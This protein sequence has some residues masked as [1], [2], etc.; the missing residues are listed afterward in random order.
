MALDLLVR[1]GAG[2]SFPPG[3]HHRE[4]ETS[5][6]LLFVGFCFSASECVVVV[7]VLVRFQDDLG[8]ECRRI[9]VGQQ[10]A[11][12][13]AGGGFGDE[14]AVGGAFDGDY[15]NRHGAAARAAKGDPLTFAKTAGLDATF[16]HS[17]AGG[18]REHLLHDETECSG[19]HG[20]SVANSSARD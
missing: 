18:Q 14:L 5:K 20:A 3:L 6:G 4:C 1:E 16:N 2:G 13:F 11:D 7:S 10:Q 9:D 17:A 19:W 8:Y 12:L 15:A